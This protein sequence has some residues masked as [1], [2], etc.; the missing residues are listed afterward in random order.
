MDVKVKIDVGGIQNFIFSVY[1]GEKGG[2][3]RTLRAR[4]FYIHALTELI[5]ELL[6]ERLKEIGIFV[7]ETQILFGSGSSEIYLR[8]LDEQK[9]ESLERAV[10]EFQ[11]VLDKF[12]LHSLKGSLSVTLGVLKEGKEREFFLRKKRRFSSYLN[13]FKG[14]VFLLTDEDRKTAKCPRCRLFFYGKKGEKERCEFCE[15]LKKL[16]QKLPKVKSFKFVKKGGEGDGGLYFKDFLPEKGLKLLEEGKKDVN[17]TVPITTVSAL[18]ELVKKGELR[19]EDLKDLLKDYPEPSDAEVVAPF[20]VIAL[21]SK[22]NKKLGYLKLDVDNLGKTFR[23]LSAFEKQKTLSDFLNNFFG[24]EVI[25]IAKEEFTPSKDHPFLK[26]TYIFILYAGGDDLFAIA[27]WDKLLDFVHK[28]YLRFKEEVKSKIS[29][30]LGLKELTFSAGFVAVPPKFTVRYTAELVDE[31]ESKAK[32]KK[33]RL[34]AFNGIVVEWE[35]LGELLCRAK[36]FTTLIEEEKIPRGLFFKFL[37]IAR[38]LKRGKLSSYPELFYFIGRNVKDEESKEKL[39]S[40]V[41]S[42]LNWESSDEENRKSLDRALF[43]TTYV[44]MATRRE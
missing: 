22:G 27:P 25:K 39:L 9:L 44:L 30:K 41:L 36:E 15:E 5:L 40:F 11:E 7:K 24:K 21:S 18:R 29:E 10:K 35:E 20:V 43:V 8:E 23:E 42:W 19:I 26:E 6:K 33:N 4:S 1:E 28:V 34:S 14:D 12:F 2:T 16:G 38:E 3:A 13:E 32:E 31:E 37:E 17:L